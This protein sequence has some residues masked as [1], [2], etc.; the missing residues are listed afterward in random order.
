MNPSPISGNMRPRPPPPPWT[1]IPDL[2][3][4]R[5]LGGDLP[6]PPSRGPQ[7][8]EPG[9]WAAPGT[10]SGW[11]HSCGLQ[12]R[13][14]ALGFGRASQKLRCTILRSSLRRQPYLVNWDPEDESSRRLTG[15]VWPLY[16]VQRSRFTCSFG[17]SSQLSGGVG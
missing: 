12:A 4:L 11:E 16:G 5:A 3:P 17:R 1:Q 10:H 7:R 14:M 15:A 6:S 2:P 8:L 9:S 13:R